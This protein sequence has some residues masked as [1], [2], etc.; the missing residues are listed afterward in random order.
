M[1]NLSDVDKVFR[2]NMIGA[3]QNASSNGRVQQVDL[4]PEAPSYTKSDWSYT[5]RKQ[6]VNSIN[7]LKKYESTSK[8]WNLKEL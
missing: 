4:T 1:N 6:L 8:L 5:K 2:Q 7:H 3:I